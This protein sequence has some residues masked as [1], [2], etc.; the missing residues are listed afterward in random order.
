MARGMGFI[1]DTLADVFAAREERPLV[2]G[3]VG[4]LFSGRTTGHA[5][6]R[7]WRHLLDHVVDQGPTNSCVGQFLSSA[8]YLAG[9]A[10]N[11]PVKRPSALWSYAGARWRD[12]YGVLE[13]IGCRPTQLMLA[14]QEH[15]LVAE[16]RWPF[17]VASVNVPPPFDADV[18]G[19]DALLTGWYSADLMDVP[20]ALRLALD[21]GHFPGVAMEV[22][23]SFYDVRPFDVF[24][25]PRGEFRGNHMVTLVGYRPGAFL[26]LNSWGR[27][28]GDDGSCWVSDRFIASHYCKQRMVVTAAPASR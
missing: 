17:E 18:A 8:V 12:N 24:D 9:Q 4:S 5:T 14:G 15:G 2:G 6:S 16:E 13:D 23:D 27:G 7:D 1:C 3:G 26:L 22:R 20:L 28:W 21:K 11:E 19:A 25:E 10:Q